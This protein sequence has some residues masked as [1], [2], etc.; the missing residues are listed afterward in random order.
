[1]PI[2]LNFIS[3]VALTLA[4]TSTYPASAHESDREVQL[5]AANDELTTR[6]AELLKENKRLEEFAMQALIAKSNNEKVVPGCDTQALRKTMV[7]G[8]GYASIAQKWLDQNGEKC[9]KEQLKYLWQNLR[10]WSSHAQN[11][12]LRYIQYLLDN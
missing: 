8:P 10:S 4:L 12:P 7:T 9:T 2:N 1:M 11:R 5:K 3:L 6:V